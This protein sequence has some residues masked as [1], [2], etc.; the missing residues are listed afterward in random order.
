MRHRSVTVRVVLLVAGVSMVVAGLAGIVVGGVA[1]RSSVEPVRLTQVSGPE[2]TIP[3]ASGVFGGSVMVYTAEPAGASPRA[4][5]C[6]LVEDD[7]DVASGTRLGAFD[8]ALADPVTVDGTTWHPFTQVEL[9]SDPATLQCSGDTLTSAALSEQSTFGRL[10][11]LVGVVALG[12]GLLGIVGGV[13]AL[14][15]AR[16]LHA[17]SR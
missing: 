12:A 11:T 17:R 13:A 9:R 6:R 10:T 4:L 5:D 7:G 8:H 2:F 14:V 15:V 16:V 1:L 3:A